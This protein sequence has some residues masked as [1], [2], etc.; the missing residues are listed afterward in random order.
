MQKT[1]K[2]DEKVRSTR[3]DRNKLKQQFFSSKFQTVQEWR[4]DKQ[5]TKKGQRNGNFHRKTKGRAEEKKKLKS[6]ALEEAK[7]EIKEE[8]KAFYKPSTQELAK[9]HQQVIQ[10]ISSKLEKM[11]IEGGSMQDL[12]KIWEILKIEKG[13]P[14][15]VEKSDQTLTHAFNSIQVETNAG[16]GENAESKPD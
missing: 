5:G 13:E 15:K 12:A 16:E 8:L 2:A 10:L 7:Q 11:L 3:Y 9:M 4:K 6:K 1:K 14:T